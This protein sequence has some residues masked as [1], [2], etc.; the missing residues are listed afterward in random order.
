MPPKLQGEIREL[1]LS[2]EGLFKLLGGTPDERERFWEILK[3]ITTPAEF[4]FA[5]STIVAATQDV[6]ALH[7]ALAGAQEAAAE[8]RTEVHA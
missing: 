1:E 6:R 8:V 2:I 4:T 7:T 3:G 5:K